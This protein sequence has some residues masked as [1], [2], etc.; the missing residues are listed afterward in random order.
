MTFFFLQLLGIKLGT[1]WPSALPLSYNPSPNIFIL[2]TFVAFFFLKQKILTLLAL[3]LKTTHFFGPLP[4][5][6]IKINCYLFAQ[7]I[8]DPELATIP[9]FIF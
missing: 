1:Y 3:Q 7:S 9:Q 6:P 5:L 4:N 8:L 2:E